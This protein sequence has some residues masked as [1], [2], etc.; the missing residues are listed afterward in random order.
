MKKM[1]KMMGMMKPEE[2]EC[3]AMDKEH[4][5]ALRDVLDE[6]ISMSS[7][8]AKKGVKA[9]MDGLQ[10]V[11]VAA[12]DQEGLEEGLEKAQDLMESVPELKEEMVAEEEPKEDEEKEDMNKNSISSY[13][14]KKKLS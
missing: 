9:G 2:K 7:E 12:P 4:L 11:T 8:E 5:I 10:K 6:L 3:G 14:K 13:F 1:M